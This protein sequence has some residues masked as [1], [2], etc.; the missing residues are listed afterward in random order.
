ME[1]MTSIEQIE[2][3]D[4]HV[5]LMNEDLCVDELMKVYVGIP[6]EIIRSAVRHLA[7]HPTHEM[8]SAMYEVVFEH[9]VTLK[10]DDHV[11]KKMGFSS[12]PNP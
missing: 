10:G 2:A 4:D 6:T 8:V 7:Q 1:M 3:H 12:T 5:R 9:F 11:K